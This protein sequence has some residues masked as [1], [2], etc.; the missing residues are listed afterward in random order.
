MN[1]SKKLELSTE[2]SNWSKEKE[3]VNCVLKRIAL[4]EKLHYSQRDIREYRDSRKLT[5]RN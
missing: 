4:M 5:G 1:R 3:C 2:E